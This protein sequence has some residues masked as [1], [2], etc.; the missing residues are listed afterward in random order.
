M[1]LLYP[2]V[3]SFFSLIIN[4]CWILSNAFSVFEI[5][6]FILHFVN[7][8]Y[9]MI[10]LWTLNHLC[11]P[12]INIIWSYWIWFAN[13]WLRIFVYFLWGILVCDFLLLVIPSL[14]LVLEKWPYIMNWESLFYIFLI[15]RNFLQLVS[16]YILFFLAFFISQLLQAL[17]C[18]F[19]IINL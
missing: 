6:F 12:R 2:F 4:E 18:L 1:F 5:W 7:M 17:V 13:I 8:V 3:E 15:R 14:V 10:D 11:L 9:M 16:I 19:F